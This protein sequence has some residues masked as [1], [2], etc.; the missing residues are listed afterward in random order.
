MQRSH[1]RQ[2]EGLLPTACSDTEAVRQLAHRLVLPCSVE[3]S[4]AGGGVNTWAVDATELRPV[5]GT[6]MLASQPAA[7]ATEAVSAAIA[8]AAYLAPPLQLPPSGTTFDPS[9]PPDVQVCVS[10]FCWSPLNADPRV[11]HGCSCVLCH[12][13]AQLCAAEKPGV[14]LCRLPC[15][16]GTIV[17][18]HSVGGSLQAW[19][20]GSGHIL[21]QPCING[22]LSGFMILDTGAPCTTSGTQ[23]CLS[24]TTPRI[25]NASIWPRPAAGQSRLWGCRW[26]SERQGTQQDTPLPACHCFSRLRLRRQDC[27][28]LRFR[29]YLVA[30]GW[31]MGSSLFGFRR[32][33]RQRAGHRAWR[34]GG[35]GAAGPGA[36]PHQ[37][38]QRQKRLLLPPRRQHP[39][40]LCGR[41]GGC[42]SSELPGTLP[43]CASAHH[44]GPCICL[45][46]TVPAHMLSSGGR[47]LQQQ[48]S[49]RPP[50][51]PCLLNWPQLARFKLSCPHGL[52]PLPSW[53]RSPWRRRSSW[54]APWM[55]WCRAVPQGRLLALSATT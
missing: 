11:D 12:A 22:R 7:A 48:P 1:C 28:E 10:H 37:R 44:E 43:L 39:G 16:D 17:V 31:W 27:A 38:F 24:P 9:L 35:A 13:V 25:T 53:G 41:N 40:M 14:S 5:C 54:S 2:P 55:A 47:S 3:H 15:I 45:P 49:H 42:S 18:L 4:A 51:S 33:R 26:W 36:G 29:E 34:G 52:V 30:A 23:T 21:V 32:C 20:T 19:K 46:R 50:S 8:A 6:Q